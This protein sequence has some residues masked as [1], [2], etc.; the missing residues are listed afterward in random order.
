[1]LN[2]NYIQCIG[3]KAQEWLREWTGPSR[4]LW[5][6]RCKKLAP[7]GWTCCHCVNE[8]Q[9]DPP[10][11]RVFSL[12]DNVW[13]ASPTYLGRKGKF[14]TRRKGGGVAATGTVGEGNPWYHPLCSRKN[15]LFFSYYYT[16]ILIRIFSM[17][18][19]L[20]TAD[21]ISHLERAIRYCTN[22]S[23]CS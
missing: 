10:V 4:W 13:E 11:T 19:G 20:E 14:I 16:P 15:S 3:H 12:W 17:G 2:G 7:P 22:H 5:Q 23:H 9:N 8:D 21:V 1:M 6:N 18:K